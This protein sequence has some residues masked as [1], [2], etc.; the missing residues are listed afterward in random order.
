M[1][2]RDENDEKLSLNDKLFC[3]LLVLVG[4]HILLV[5]IP[6]TIEILF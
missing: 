5:D 3:V 4:L 6:R 1:K 2:K